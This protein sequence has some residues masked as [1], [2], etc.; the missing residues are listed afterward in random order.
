MRSTLVD[1]CSPSKLL[2]LLGL[3]STTPLSDMPVLTLLVGCAVLCCVL[4]SMP[5]CAV[6]YSVRSTD[7]RLA[8]ARAMLS[9]LYGGGEGHHR[10]CGLH[11]LLPNEWQVRVYGTA[12]RDVWHSRGM[13][14]SCNHPRGQGLWGLGGAGRRARARLIQLL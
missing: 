11:V 1:S 13:R 6:L 8:E 4:P 5:C 12:S 9:R 2:E 10:S 3:W 7:P 14:D